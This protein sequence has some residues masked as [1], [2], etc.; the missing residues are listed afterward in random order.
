MNESRVAH[1]GR[2][3]RRRFLALTAG[4]LGLGAMRPELNQ[5]Q[6]AAAQEIVP[7]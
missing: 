7:V 1:L 4:A 6:I 5:I 3:A 2:F